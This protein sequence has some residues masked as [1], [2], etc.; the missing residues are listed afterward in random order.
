VVRLLGVSEDRRERISVNEIRLS[1][2]MGWAY[3]P[4]V[5]RCALLSKIPC[6]PYIAHLA[7]A[8][9]GCRLRALRNEL[10]QKFPGSFARFGRPVAP[11]I[12]AGSRGRAALGGSQDTRVSD[13]RED[14]SAIAQN[15]GIRAGRRPV[16]HGRP[17]RPDRAA[18]VVTS[19]GAA[20]RTPPEHQDNGLQL[21]A[22]ASPP[23]Q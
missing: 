4:E 19:S 20:I 13:A 6:Q 12:G 16:I 7:A 14:Y 17:I 3:H 23:Q 21:A 22:R 15:G 2:S 1:G 11:P 9:R 10:R 5:V 8:D 18:A